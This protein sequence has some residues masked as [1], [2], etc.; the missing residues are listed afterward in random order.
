M[1][2]YFC[3]SFCISV[4]LERR[5][6]SPDA[7]QTVLFRRALH[8]LGILTEQRRNFE[9]RA[10]DARWIRTLTL[11]L[12]LAGRGEDVMLSS[13]FKEGNQKISLLYCAGFAPAVQVFLAV[14]QFTEDFV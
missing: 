6:E 12:S 8:N 14:A 11:I 10:K 13:P 9:S 4:I 7:S 3:L 1:G 5:E 2:C